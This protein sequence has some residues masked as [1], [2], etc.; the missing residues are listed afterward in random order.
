MRGRSTLK[1]IFFKII[2]NYRLLCLDRRSVGII[3]IE[4]EPR[5]PTQKGVIKMPRTAETFGLS[6]S[7]IAARARRAQQS[8]EC[9]ARRAAREAGIAIPSTSNRATRRSIFNHSVPTS[10]LTTTLGT[11]AAEWFDNR[12]FGIEI[13]CLLPLQNSR[14]ILMNEMRIRGLHVEDNG[15][16]H[17]DSTTT[18][19][20]VSDSSVR[21]S[22]STALYYGCEV[23]SPILQGEDGRS[24]L[25][26]ACEALVVVKA[27]VNTTCGLHIHHGTTDFTIDSFKKLAKY[28]ASHQEE[29]D[30][31]LAP[32]RRSTRNPQYCGGIK[33]MLTAS[34][35]QNAQTI[36][37]FCQITGT[38]YASVNFSAFLRHGTIEFRQHQGTVNFDK[39]VEWLGFGQSM[40]RF[41]ANTQ[42]VSSSSMWNDLHCTA[43]HLA[44]WM[45]R[46]A[47]LRSAA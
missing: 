39:I 30:M 13:E 32:S 42:T 38:R 25:R 40:M 23:V 47:S 10:E 29:I 34:R 9:R 46:V 28:Y 12:T 21:G 1:K 19:K 6:Q 3:Y 7:E 43:K 24:Q 5:A 31:M 27:K 2:Q 26:R 15:Y 41:A 8:R 14:Q 18:W 35:L 44:F 33:W 37:E 17:N 20:L 36:H 22:G 16:N 11:N 4:R 45:K